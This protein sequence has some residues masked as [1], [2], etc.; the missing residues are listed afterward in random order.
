MTKRDNAIN[1][2]R[3]YE[4]INPYIVKLKRDV[5][6]YQKPSALTDFG[7]EY[8]I[9]N[10]KQSPVQIGKTFRIADWYGNK[11]REDYLIEFTPEKMLFLLGRNDGNLSLY[12]EIQAEYGAFGVICSKESGL[13]K[14]V[15]T[16]LPYCKCGF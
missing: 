8:I 15:H 1:I 10:E 16:R 13:G 6:A 7:V 4:G 11:L 9:E 14:P 5:V 2:L 3:N 12:G